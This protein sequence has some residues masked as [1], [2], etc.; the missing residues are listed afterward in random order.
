MSLYETRTE[1][2]PGY[3]KNNLA[4]ASEESF[5]CELG[6]MTRNIITIF[7]AVEKRKLRVKA[8]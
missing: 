1:P 3:V 5:T 8:P 2:V 7:N 6:I 4:L